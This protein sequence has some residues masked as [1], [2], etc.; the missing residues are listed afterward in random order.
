MRR[1]LGSNSVNPQQIASLPLPAVLHLA[2]LVPRRLKQ[3]LLDS[4]SSHPN[5]SNTRRVLHSGRQRLNQHARPRVGLLLDKLKL[6]NCQPLLHLHSD[7]PQAA[8][9]SDPRLQVLLLAHSRWHLHRLHRLA[10]EDP[11]VHHH[12][13]LRQIRSGLVRAQGSPRL[14]PYSKVSGL[15]LPEARLRRQRYHLVHLHRRPQQRAIV[16]VPFS[17]W[18]LRRRRRRNHQVSVQ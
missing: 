7:H 6:S 5:K 3:H 14:L 12:N 11:Q 16:E 1:L 15:I 17:R 10:S 18:E 2:N 13:S 4:P 9:H 8:V